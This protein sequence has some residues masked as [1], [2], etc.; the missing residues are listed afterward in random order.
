MNP[1][2]VMTFTLMVAFLCAAPIAFGQGTDLGTI[3][4]T[5][6]DASGSVVANADITITDNATG[7]ARAAKTNGSGEY[8][9]FGLKSGTYKVVVNSAG[10]AT[11]Q[12]DNVALQGSSVVGVNVRLRVSSAQEKIE[13]TVAAP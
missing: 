10:F 8:Q 13:V 4:G 7:A 2:I 6:T 1:R 9:V 12:V 11:E 5:V 3:R